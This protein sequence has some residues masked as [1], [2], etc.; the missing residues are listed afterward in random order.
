MRVRTDSKTSG[1]WQW[2]MKSKFEQRVNAKYKKLV[3]V[4]VVDT[5]TFTRRA[6]D[7]LDM[8]TDKISRPISTCKKGCSHCCTN[9]L[10]GISYIEYAYITEVVPKEKI[11]SDIPQIQDS[12]LWKIHNNELNSDVLGDCPFLENNLCSIYTHRPI[13]CRTFFSTD[14]VSLCEKGLS[15]QL[16]NSSS[17][18][19]TDHINSMFQG[20]SMDEIPE[21]SVLEIRDFFL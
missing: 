7:I 5:T 6:Y 16:V 15:H 8:I 18:N 14:D 2:H 20:I 11:R 13:A 9:S 21:H 17:N 3:S 12:L 10:I 19:M 1:I 4:N